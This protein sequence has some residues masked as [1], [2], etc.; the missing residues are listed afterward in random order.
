MTSLFNKYPLEFAHD[1]VD[2]G[3]TCLRMICRYYGRFFSNEY[4]GSISYLSHDGVSLQSLKEAAETIGFT[5]VPVRLNCES[6]DNQLL[7][8]ILH[9]NQDHFVVLYKISRRSIALQKNKQMFKI[10]DPSEGMIS[11][12]KDTLEKHWIGDGGSKKGTA[13]LLNPESIFFEHST[14]K[15]ST[16]KLRNTIKY[17][18]PHKKIFLQVSITLFIGSLISLVF[19][20]LMQTLIDQGVD[21]K[22]ISI[23]YLILLSQTLLFLGEAVLG[24]I[25]SWLLMYA[26]TR[27]SFTIISEFLYKL[28]KLP[29]KFY[30]SKK[31]GDFSQRIDD[32]N[33][34]ERFLTGSVLNTIFS[35]LSILVYIIIIG[36][37]IINAKGF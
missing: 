22:N 30:E 27:I 12:D 1:S 8:C 26:G 5:A 25:R 15:P 14:K 3:P 17:L 29:I 28:F 36:L 24:N 6:L 19:P 37:G 31:I 32:H 13:L 20:L 34:I 18:Y 21:G 4:L 23:V 35:I 7:P 9:W 11:I 10:A 16:S 2:C 33:R